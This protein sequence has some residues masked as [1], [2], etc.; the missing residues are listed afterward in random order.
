MAETQDQQQP[1]DDMR[2]EI[3]ESV[4][5]EAREIID[6]LNLCLIQLDEDLND[7]ALIETITRGF[8][9]VKGSSSFAGLDQLVAIA[10]ALE[11]SMREVKKGAVALTPSAVNL[12]YDGLDAITAIIDKAEANDF[13]AIDASQLLEKVEKFKSGKGI[14]ATSAPDDAVEASAHEYDELL[15]IYRD[16]YNQ[17]TALKH[18]IFASLHLRDPETLAVMLSKQIHDYIAP[19]RN[20]LWLIDKDDKIIETARNGKL[21]EKE[22]RRIFRSADSEIFQRVLHEQLIHWP[23]DPTVFQA[24]LPEYESPVIFPIKIKTEVLGILI[25]DLKEKV[26]IELFQFIVQFAAMIMHNCLLHQKVAEQHEALD[27][28]TGILFKQNAHLSSMHHIE[29][30]L[31][32]EMDPA[33]QCQIVVDSMVS[34]LATVRAAAFIYYPS[35]KEFLC[36]AESGGFK[37]IVGTRFPLSKIR[38]LQEALET[39]RLIAHV[40]YGE[41]LTIGKNPLDMW[42]ALGIK[43]RKKI[44]GVLVVELGDEEFSDAISIIAQFLGVLLDNVISIQKNMRSES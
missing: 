3:L 17:L 6:H 16:G 21:V 29:M 39:G 30:M 12:L 1:S 15:K 34:D 25:L 8:H 40:D 44:H 14:D 19:L 20:S 7:E 35:K 11:M 10:K 23:A 18:M 37:D 22:E 13:T 9:T 27:E 5:S 32:Q 42:I 24:D 43:G 31:I 33:K 36:A 41:T 38:A 2:D 28:M 4:I 26:E